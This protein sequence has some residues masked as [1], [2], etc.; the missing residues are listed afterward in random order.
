MTQCWRN[1]YQKEKCQI[2]RKVFKSGKKGLA[3]HMKVYHQQY[4]CQKP[5]CDS[6]NF[7][8]EDELIEHVKK[9]FCCSKCGKYFGSVEGFKSHQEGCEPFKITYVKSDNAS[10]EPETLSKSHFAQCGL[11]DLIKGVQSNAE[12]S[13]QELKEILED[14]IIPVETEKERNFNHAILVGLLVNFCSNLTYS[15]KEIILN[16]KKNLKLNCKI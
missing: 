7:H 6:E 12:K 13:D 11:P 16:I 14:E 15:P 4:I 1:I 3:H 9:C 8:T 10:F 2:C 5:L